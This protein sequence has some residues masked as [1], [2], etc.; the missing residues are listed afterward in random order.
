MKNEEFIATLQ[1]NVEA[2]ISQIVSL[3]K[4]YVTDLGGF[5]V[6]VVT[7]LFSILIKGMILFLMCIFF[8]IEKEGVINFIP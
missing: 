4:S 5:A 7:G 8:S 3:G 2:N 1:S 6:S